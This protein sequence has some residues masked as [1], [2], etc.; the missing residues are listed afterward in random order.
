MR[1]EN[2]TKEVQTDN[3]YAES[4]IKKVADEIAKQLNAQ[5]K[6]FGHITLNEI[7]KLSRGR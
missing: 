6:K 7:I 1:I 3:T 2:T 5:D 4:A